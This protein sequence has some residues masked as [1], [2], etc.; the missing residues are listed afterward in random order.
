MQKFF[1]KWF[2]KI[3]PLKKR[4]D[5]IYKYEIGL[6]QFLMNYSYL[7]NSIFPNNKKKN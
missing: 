3:K 1:I 7:C 2:Y 5:I 6:S 4:M